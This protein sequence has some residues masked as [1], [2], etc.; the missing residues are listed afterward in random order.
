[1]VRRKRDQL[2][3]DDGV[4]AG[5]RRDEFLDQFRRYVRRAIGDR[6]FFVRKVIEKRAYRDSGFGADRLDRHLVETALADQAHRGAADVRAGLATASLAQ[7]YP[8]RHT[9]W[10]HVMHTLQPTATIQA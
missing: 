8:T 9:S 5:A 1:M 3:Q 2:M 6:R 7:T 4:R 10:L